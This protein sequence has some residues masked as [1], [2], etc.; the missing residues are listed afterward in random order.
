MTRGSG[1]RL[2]VLG[3]YSVAG[4]GH[5]PPLS[6]VIGATGPPSILIADEAVA[7]GGNN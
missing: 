1:L 6:F 5:K 4:M 7:S 2:G 3:A